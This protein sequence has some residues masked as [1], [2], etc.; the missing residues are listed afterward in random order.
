MNATAVRIRGPQQVEGSLGS[1]SGAQGEHREGPAPQHLM[2]LQ[3]ANQIRLA[4]A[5]I[6]RRV[7]LGEL[8]VVDVLLSGAE[9]IETMEIAELLTSQRRWGHTRARR[10]LAAIPMTESKTI[11]SMTQRQLATLASMLAA[12]TQRAPRPLAH[13]AEQVAA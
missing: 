2:A 4:R 8:S 13:Q 1:Q 9:E 10:F 3:R 11:G 12:C 7:A 6:K 5:E